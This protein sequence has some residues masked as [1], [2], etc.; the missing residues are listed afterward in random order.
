MKKVESMLAK[1]LI[2]TAKVVF[3]EFGLPKKLVSHAGTNFVSEQFKEFCRHLNRDQIMMSSY[4]H[5]GNGHVEACIKFV[6]CMI[7]KGRQNNKDF[8]FAFR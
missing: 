5:Q 7:K 1:D 3:A 2:C 4:H 6:K 8:Q